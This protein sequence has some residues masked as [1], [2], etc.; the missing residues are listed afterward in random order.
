[1]MAVTK[2][3]DSTM[4]IA[5]PAGYWHGLL[6]AFGVL[7]AIALLL[8]FWDRRHFWA[9][10]AMGAMLVSIGSG[11]VIT[12]TGYMLDNSYKHLS[13][14]MEELVTVVEEKLAEQPVNR[15]QHEL[16][17]LVESVDGLPYLAVVSLEP[18]RGSIVAAYPSHLLGE[19]VDTKGL[20]GCATGPTIQE[21]ILGQLFRQVAFPAELNRADYLCT[22]MDV[23][24]LQVEQPYGQAEPSTRMLIW[25][26]YVPCGQLAPWEKVNGLAY[27]LCFVFFAAYWVSVTAWVYKDAGRHG[28]PRLVWG[29][30]VLFTNVVGLVVYLV[31]RW[32]RGK[33]YFPS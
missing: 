21:Y 33:R 29:G 16:E 10:L 12:Y 27:H 32:R 6:A 17:Q 30:L 8:W 4:L 20:P 28:A 26:H 19:S 31:L 24:P 15:W 5:V 1:M 13:A 3:T 2:A 18:N 14:P 25:A 11:A 22:T 7:L 23:R 9:R